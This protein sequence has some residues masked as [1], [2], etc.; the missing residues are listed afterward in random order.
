[1][2]IVLAILLFA[3]VFYTIGTPTTEIAEVEEDYPICFRS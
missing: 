1:M 2:N 3:I